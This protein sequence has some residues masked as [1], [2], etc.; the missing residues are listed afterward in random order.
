MT[1]LF[2]KGLYRLGL[3]RTKVAGMFSGVVCIVGSALVPLINM[4]SSSR[5]THNG[6]DVHF[7]SYAVL[8]WALIA[9]API[10]MYTA[11]SFLTN[12]RDSDFYHSLPHKRI[13]LYLSLFAAA[14]T[15]IWG[16][17]LATV[18][19]CGA[20]WLVAGTSISFSLTWATVGRT[21]LCFSVATLCTSAFIPA[22]LAATGTTISAIALYGCVMLVPKLA[23][24]VFST[25][26]T[27][28]APF[29]YVSEQVQQYFA[30]GLF[31]TLAMLS[32]DYS[33]LPLIYTIVLA[34][35]HIALGLIIFCRRRSESAGT[36]APGKRLQTLYRS[37]ISV[38]TM[39]LLV[40]AAFMD[41]DISLLM[42]LVVVTVV[43]Y[44][45][46]EL[47]TTKKI[48]SMLAATATLWILPAFCLVFG[49]SIWLSDTVSWAC[50]PTEVENIDHIRIAQSAQ[51]IDDGSDILEYYKLAELPIYDED[52][53]TVTT[54][55]LKYEHKEAYSGSNYNYALVELTT[56]SGRTVLRKLYTVY[57][58][59]RDYYEYYYD[60]K[61]DVWGVGSSEAPHLPDGLSSLEGIISTE[62]LAENNN[63][64]LA[65][66]LDLVHSYGAEHGVDSSLDGDNVKYYSISLF[67]GS[68]QR[69][70]CMYINDRE[71]SSKY[72]VCRYFYTDDSRLME[73]LLQCYVAEFNSLSDDERRQ[74]CNT[75]KLN[76]VGGICIDAEQ[77]AQRSW[78]YPLI[79]SHITLAVDD[80]MTPRSSELLRRLYDNSD[81]NIRI[82]T[83]VELA[84]VE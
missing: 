43:I 55:L 12:R 21:L 16:I 63:D 26:L 8:L 10:I 46:Y 9:L 70:Y 15:W 73:E 33:P 28:F 2:D 31:H 42:V 14:M 59:Y 81:V 60:E 41:S 50:T 68:E 51:L 66:L 82:D 7:Y 77:L 35:A 20:L 38:P 71:I 49:G 45:L 84:E 47:I 72:I 32:G 24:F 61:S 74:L 40:Y 18:A 17:L 36:P 23:I 13:T 69:G 11:F 39:L 4:I 64:V 3:R 57:T 19:I 54:E 27:E 37:L 44:Y 65:C 30:F 80:E 25:C 62:L 58:N 34:L 22:A 56:T 52:I 5:Y 6:F 78:N 53:I 67:D 29:I 76:T 83:T 48:R 1:K 79:S 75:S